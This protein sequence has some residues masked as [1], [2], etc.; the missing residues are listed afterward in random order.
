[1]PTESTPLEEQTEATIAVPRIASDAQVHSYLR[2][3]FLAVP[4]G[5]CWSTTT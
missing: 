1:M 3:G 5:A 4:T 2:D